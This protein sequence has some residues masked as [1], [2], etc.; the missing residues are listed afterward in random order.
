MAGPEK[1]SKGGGSRGTSSGGGPRERL[2]A[3]ESKELTRRDD[4]TLVLTAAERDIVEELVGEAMQTNALI[5]AHVVG[6]GGRIFKK[7]FDNSTAAVL[8]EEKTPNRVWRELKRRAG[9]PT[10][11]MTAEML[12]VA[13]RV[14]VWDKS[15]NDDNFRQLDLERKKLLL[16]LG[17]AELLRKAAQHV[18][19]AKLTYRAT[20]LY[21]KTLRTDDGSPPNARVSERLVDGRLGGVVERFGTVTQRQAIAR[22]A[23]K[24]TPEKRRALAK[25][26]DAAIAALRATRGLIEE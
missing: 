14:A 11:R 17:K 25:K 5:E 6:L 7:A 23:A 1:G 8:G 13:L 19:D 21:V 3:D 12:D 10:L 24:L 4:G 18:T 15:V 16:P 26:V 2:S 22:M 9:G 20:K